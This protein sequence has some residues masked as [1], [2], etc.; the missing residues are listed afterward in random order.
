MG[1]DKPQTAFTKE[2]AEAILQ[3]ELRVEALQAE[4]EREERRKSKEGIERE[5]K[6]DL[7]ADLEQQIENIEAGSE[8][9]FNKEDLECW[10][11]NKKEELKE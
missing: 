8:G 7:I 11:S 3:A 4:Q 10:I 9:D 6:L 5:A 2:G 1:E